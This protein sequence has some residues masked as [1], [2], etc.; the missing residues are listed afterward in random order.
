MKKLITLLTIAI[1]A[2]SAMGQGYQT[3]EQNEV[4]IGVPHNDGILAV[5][6]INGQVSVKGT[7]RSDILIKYKLKAKPKSVRG[8]DRAKED[9]SFDISK[10]GDSV[11]VALNGPFVN[12]YRGRQH[13]NINSND[14][15]Y[16]FICNIDLEVP[17]NINLEVAT[18]NDGNVEIKNITGSVIADNVN[19]D[20]SINKMNG[21]VITETVNGDIRIDFQSNP[22]DG[23]NFRTINGNIRTNVPKDLSANISFKSMNGEFYTDFDYLTGETGRVVKDASNKRGIQYKIEQITKVKIG[24]GKS[25]L[26]YETLNGDMFLRK[27]N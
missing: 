9:L 2:S 5:L 27:L 11:A 12:Y 26:F 21:Q 19:G 1:I 3:I 17:T 22:G 8:I 18:I 13:V 4:T 7:N 16:W 23:S 6:N 10:L 14:L 20:V 25:S 15:D 24:S